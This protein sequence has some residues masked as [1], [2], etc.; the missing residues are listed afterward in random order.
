MRQT[1]Y[2]QT[3]FL[4]RLDLQIGE[5]LSDASLNV[6]KL[7]RLVGMSRTDLHR[8]LHETVGMS[9]T[10]YMRHLRLRRAV[11]LL[12]EQPDLSILQVASAVGFDNQGYF[13]RKFR[14]VFGCC[15]RAYR[16]ENLASFGKMEGF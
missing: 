16:E 2:T 6:K 9:T 12:V 3:V 14:D 8:K 15:P 7:L 10:A 5:H 11:A 1:H 4:P 13:T